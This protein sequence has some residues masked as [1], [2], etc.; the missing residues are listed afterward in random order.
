MKEE[1]ME[2]KRIG[3]RTVY[4]GKVLDF[5]KDRMVL[6]DGAEEEWDFVHH[7]KGGGAAVVPV[8]PDGRI[9]MIR[10]M[11]PAV[12]RE[13]LEIPAGAR[14]AGEDPA[15]TAARELCEETGYRA[16]RLS[17][18]CTIDT[19][20]AWCDE[21]TEI[22]LAEELVREGAQML[23]EAEEILVEACSAR[24]LLAGIQNGEIR[25][26]KTVAGICAYLSLFCQG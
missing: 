11:R 18:L 12:D 13:T 19:A 17:Y 1:R 23:D 15:V 22:F 16:G 10:Q 3:R 8:L 4:E 5:C 26:A 24:D 21:K 2:L 7:H 14:D 20:V 9:L 6:P 25:D